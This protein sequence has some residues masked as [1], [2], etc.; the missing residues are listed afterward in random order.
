MPLIHDQ[1]YEKRLLDIEDQVSSTAKRIVWGSRISI[2]LLLIG[3]WILAV[4]LY[5]YN[6][7]SYYAVILIGC[8]YVISMSVIK[9]LMEIYR[10]IVLE[11]T[12]IEWIGRKQLGEY[13]PPND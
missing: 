8:T 2:P 3:V 5:P 4:I 9:N 11:M 13:E 1:E 12:A 6:E 10:V 7:K